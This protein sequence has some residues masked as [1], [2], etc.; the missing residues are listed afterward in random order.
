MLKKQSDSSSIMGA[1]GINAVV[2][3]VMGDGKLASQSQ[4]KGMVGAIVGACSSCAGAS[5][6]GGGHVGAVSEKKVL[7]KL[8][9]VAPVSVNS[10]RDV[11]R[12]LGVGAVS[13]AKPSAAQ[14]QQ[15]HNNVTRAFGIDPWNQGAQV[16]MAKQMGSH[17]FVAAVS[18]GTNAR[19]VLVMQVDPKTK[20]PLQAFA[21]MADG[22]KG[23]V[24]NPVQTISSM[25]GATIGAV[26]AGSTASGGA[27][28][29]EVPVS[30]VA[31]LPMRMMPMLQ[32][33]PTKTQS[34]SSAMDREA[35]ISQAQGRDLPG[36]SVKNVSF[37]NRVDPMF[38]MNT[39]V[40]P[41]IS[42]HN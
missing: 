29:S 41:P 3:A 33:G 20:K 16:S 21:V 24:K 18:A 8:G 36:D 31:Q 27:S 6:I 19:D 7:S 15:F 35:L 39:S 40:R 2:A 9:I 42:T 37:N 30:T 12:R 11:M 13:V 23:M 4:L 1:L 10:Q 25:Q 32:H 22:R 38:I 26:M 34:V 17:Q 28:R 5:C 14:K